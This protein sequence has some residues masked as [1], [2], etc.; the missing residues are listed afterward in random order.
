MA[1]KSKTKRIRVTQKDIDAGVVY[2]TYKCPIAIAVGRAFDTQSVCARLVDLQVQERHF[3]TPDTV[4]AFILD[5]DG[6]KPVKPFSF[7]LKE[8]E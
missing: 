3:D 5:F 2:N 6:C 8:Q 1:T 4:R 7:T